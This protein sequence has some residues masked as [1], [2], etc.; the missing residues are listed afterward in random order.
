[1]T[2]Y[3]NDDTSY[4][5]GSRLSDADIDYITGTKVIKP[6]SFTGKGTLS[7]ILTMDN[8]INTEKRFAI[9]AATENGKYVR[10]DLLYYKLNGVEIYTSLN[11]IIMVDTYNMTMFIREAAKVSSGILPE[12]PEQKQYIILYTDLEYEDESTEYP[13][14]WE[15]I[16][17][18]KNVY[19]AIK[20]NAAVINIDKSIVMVDTVAVKDSLTVREFVKYLQNANLVDEEDIFDIDEYCGESDVI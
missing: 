15:S 4:L 9:T 2:D 14:R 1:M 6:I 8:Q 16:I 10:G 11:N 18:R 17:G 7:P 13:Y 5:L 20:A 3:A 12:N 19:N